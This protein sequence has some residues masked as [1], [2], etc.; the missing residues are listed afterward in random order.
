MKNLK[1]NIFIIIVIALLNYSLAFAWEDKTT[2]PAL[3]DRAIK[4]LQETGWIEPYFQ[5]NLGFKKHVEEFLNNGEK[6]ITIIDLLLEGSREED[7]WP[8]KKN[9]DTM[10]SINHFHSPID[11]KK[12]IRGHHTN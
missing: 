4:H 3:T 7:A 5:N 11:N 12:E 10:R 8:D 6:D 2:H 1:T 9:K